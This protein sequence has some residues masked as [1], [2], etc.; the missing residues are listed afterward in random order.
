MEGPIRSLLTGE[1]AISKSGAR[2]QTFVPYGRGKKEET[3]VG[4]L[5]SDSFQK[6]DRV[7]TYLK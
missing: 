5:L 6:C 4:Q 7:E 1:E 2:F 3:R